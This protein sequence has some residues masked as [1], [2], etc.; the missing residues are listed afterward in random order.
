M[1]NRL[2]RKGFYLT[3]LW[4]IWPGLAGRGLQRCAIRR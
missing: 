3:W 1:L 2:Y 4:W